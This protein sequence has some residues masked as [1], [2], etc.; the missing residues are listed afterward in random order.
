M[1]FGAES[2]HIAVRII[3]ESRPRA[4]EP[5]IRQSYLVQ[6]NPRRSPRQD[7]YTGTRIRPPAK[8]SVGVS[9][10][11]LAWLMEDHATLH[12]ITCER[13]LLT[14][15]KPTGVGGPQMPSYRFC[16]LGI[17][18]MVYFSTISFPPA[19]DRL[20]TRDMTESLLTILWVTLLER[21]ERR[22]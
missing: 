2:T 16:Q 18:D 3:D 21:K 20:Q 19:I 4:F 13:S 11:G 1:D 14:M 17:Q 15:Y 6:F 9:N 10:R 7:C 22:R 12:D 8:F 5:S